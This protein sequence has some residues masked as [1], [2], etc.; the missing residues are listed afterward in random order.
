MNAGFNV[1]GADG[2]RSYGYDAVGNRTQATI[3]G[4]NT[5]A[6]YD[7]ADRITAAGS[8]S[9]TVDDAGNTTAKGSDTF[10][11]DQANRMTS[12]TVGGTTETYAYDGDGVRFSS[13]VSGQSSVRYV[14]DPA[15]SLPRTIDDGT[16]TYVWASD[17]P[18]P[19][20]AR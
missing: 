17:S 13:Q 8:T 3:S 7:A 6:T 18:T 1:T 9:I 14:T 15:A 19:W 16:R 20:P 4:T 12:A 2:T 5:V 10:A 11:Y